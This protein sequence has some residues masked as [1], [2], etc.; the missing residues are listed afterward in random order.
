MS[1]ISGFLNINKPLNMTSHDVVA[2]IRRTFKIKKV[3]HA[4][5]LDPL[6]TGILIIC[7][8]NATRLSEYVMH[9]TKHY[10]ARVHLGVTTDT[11]DAEG[12]V[13]QERDPSHI[14]LVDVEAKLG[15]FLGD[16]E[17]M[18]PMY[19]AIKQGGQKLYDLARAG[20][21]V[22][23]ELRPV[24]IASLKIEDWSPPEFTLDVVCSAGTYIRSLA[25][26]LG[27]ALDVGAHLSGLSRVSSGTFQLENALTLETL[28]ASEDWHQYLIPPQVALA[29]WPTVQLSEEDADHILH[30]RA[31]QAPQTSN[32]LSFAYDPN[33]QLIAILRADAGLW[34]PHKV[35]SD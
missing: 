9:A 2:K 8:G 4:G 24:K 27:E 13:F 19:S 21:T 18:P 30:G 17:Q 23:R 25:F 3:G 14:Q 11:Y 6:A 26:D 10:R 35:F 22:E 5:T 31:I 15:A 7:V 33:G 28:F 29:D 34:R 16:I 12:A 32:E 20:Q 1:D